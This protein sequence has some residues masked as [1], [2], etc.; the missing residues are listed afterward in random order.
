MQKTH[1]ILSSASNLLGITLLII[2]GLHV[3]NASA[4]SFS[5]EVAWAGAV[6]FTLSWWLGLYLLARDPRKPPLVLAA[7][8]LT[9]F[10]LVVALDAVRVISGAKVLSQIEIYLVAVPAIAWFG[11]SRT[12]FASTNGPSAE[13]TPARPSRSSMAACGSAAKSS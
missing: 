12:V 8:G 5:D 7:V 1:H 10:A 11:L 4:Q 9:S 2:A 6:C 13:T 3:A